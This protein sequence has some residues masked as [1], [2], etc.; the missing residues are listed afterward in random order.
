MSKKTWRVL[1]KRYDSR[2]REDI[3]VECPDVIGATQ[4]AVFR[5]MN[6][7]DGDNRLSDI[8]SIKVEDM[9]S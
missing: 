1:I 9:Q 4:V 8:Q 6:A 7:R 3:T 5:W 2:E